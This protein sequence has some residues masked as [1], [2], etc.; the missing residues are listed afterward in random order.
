ML[1]TSLFIEP[2]V[3]SFELCDTHLSLNVFFKANKC[4][5]ISITNSNIVYTISCGLK[6]GKGTLDLSKAELRYSKGRLAIVNSDNHN[7]T[8]LAIKCKEDIYQKVYLYFSET[9]NSSSYSS[10]KKRKDDFF[11]K[12]E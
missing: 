1:L 11:R 4:G 10:Q 2:H 8:I 7:K 12:N 9:K 3:E 5:N 6:I